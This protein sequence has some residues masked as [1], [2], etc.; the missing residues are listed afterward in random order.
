[1]DAKDK[2]LTQAIANYAGYNAK[3]TLGVATPS[4]FTA[5]RI[6]EALLLRD[7]AR[8]LSPIF[9]RVL[10]LGAEDVGKLSA[11]LERYDSKGCVPHFDLSTDGLVPEVV[12]ALT[13]RGFEPDDALHYLSRKPKK[14]VRSAEIAVERWGSDQAD[15][16]R[17]LLATSGATCENSVW[18]KRR[19]LYCTD[20]FRVFIALVNGKPRAWATSFA[21]NGT[22]TAFLANAFTDPEYRG[23]GCHTALLDARIADA[24]ELGFELAFT[25]VVPDSTSSR[26]CERVGFMPAATMTLW[27]RP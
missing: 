2:L 10:G 11:I 8:P 7:P 17:E 16:F 1:M 21:D 24:M 13:E 5:E 26:N 19:S 4:E 14:K 25:D 27:R 3:R 15:E 23:R 6:G 20:Q 22:K 12:L 18:E 9:N